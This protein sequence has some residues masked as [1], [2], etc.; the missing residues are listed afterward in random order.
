MYSPPEVLMYN[1]YSFGT[2]IWALG[3]VMYLMLSGQYPFDPFVNQSLV[4]FY[5]EHL[6]ELE[7]N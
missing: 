5:L 3:V 6:L 2:D 4:H 1:Q 7:N